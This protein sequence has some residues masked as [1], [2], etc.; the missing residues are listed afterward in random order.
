MSIAS[1]ASPVSLQSF[2]TNRTTFP[3]RTADDKTE[4]NAES[5]SNKLAPDIEKDETKLAEKEMVKHNSKG[6]KDQA[7]LKNVEIQQKQMSGTLMNSKIKEDFNSSNAESVASPRML[8][9]EYIPSGD[10]SKSSAGVYRLEKAEDGEQRIV[11]DRPDQSENAEKSEQANANPA[12][13]VNGSEEKA[14]P[15]EDADS[16]KKTDEPEKKD[17][18]KEVTCTG[19]TDKVDREIKQLKKKKQQLEQQLDSVRSDEDKRKEIE[20]QLS[21]VN[22]ELNMKD[23]DSYRKQHTTYVMM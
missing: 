4:P 5:E 23:N 9:D 8:R 1:I 6:E 16:P 2:Y 20:A 22:S 17:N 15:I 21:Q 19:N 18:K 11:F 13:P 7:D 14:E 3:Q 12:Q 10:Q